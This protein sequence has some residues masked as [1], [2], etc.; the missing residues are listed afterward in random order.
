MSAGVR[1]LEPPGDGSRADVRPLAVGVDVVDVGRLARVLARRGAALT[2][3]VFTPAERE[4]CGGDVR[5]LAARFAAKEAAA[6]ALG[7]GIGPVAWRDVE[8]APTRGA[9]HLV[10]RGAARTIALERGLDRWEL[11]L[12]HDPT[13]AVA[14]VVAAGSGDPR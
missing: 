1:P 9:P 13:H 14:V 5:R 6:K 4:G 12:A 3:R 2:E 7:T 11:S 10:L 8:A